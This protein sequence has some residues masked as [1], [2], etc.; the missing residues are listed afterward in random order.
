MK[1]GQAMS[2]FEAAMPEEVAGPYRAALTKLQ[3]AAPPLPGRVDPRD[4][5][6]GA[7]RRLARP[8]RRVRRQARRGCVDRAGAQ[9]RLARRSRR[10]REGAVPRCRQGAHQRP[11]PDDPDGQAVRLL[12]PRHGHQAAARGAEGPRDR[13]AGLPPRV[14]QPA[15]LRCC[16]RGRPR[17]R[18][19]PRAR[20]LTACRGVRVDRRSP[21]VVDHLRRH[22]G[23]ARSRR[24]ALPAVPAG[25]ACARGTAALRPP[26]RQLPDDSGGEV[27]H[28]RLRCGGRAAP[29]PAD[30]DGDAAAHRALR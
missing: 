17:V 2:I 11:Q 20:G 26:P 8:L 24:R 5:A 13:G 25:R 9:G 6:R 16:V 4:P 27:L 12:G 30:A 10:R 14:A 19:A 3:E 29:R 7:R 18:R 28:P 21:A 22:A 15:R 1:M 23:G